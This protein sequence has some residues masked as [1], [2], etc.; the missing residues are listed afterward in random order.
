LAV[1]SELYESKQN[2]DSDVEYKPFLDNM[3]EKSLCDPCRIAESLCTLP[4]YCSASV[5][6]GIFP[7]QRQMQQDF[8]KNKIC[9]FGYK[10]YNEIL[11]AASRH[12]YLQ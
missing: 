7:E 10:N 1:G 4:W 12:S 9:F 8:A 3:K 5:G 2:D 11:N 6:I